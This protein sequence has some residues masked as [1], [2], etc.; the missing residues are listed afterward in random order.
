MAKE[1]IE[2]KRIFLRNLNIKDAK[3]IVKICHDKSI[4]RF[5]HVP[6]PYRLKDAFE[7]IKRSQKKR[8]ESEEFVYGIINKETDE[9]MGTISFIRISKRDNKAEIGYLLGKEY[10][11]KGYMTE[12]CKLLV[13]YGFKK[14]KFYKICINCAKGNKE[15][16]KVIEKVGGKEEALLRKD[17]LLGGKYHDH[18]IH[19]LWRDDWKKRR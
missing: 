19:S 17:I 9:L 18:Y 4:N 16:K 13:D 2:G 15:S 12:A 6:Y 5:T 14:M 8:K 1:D 11:N 7:F 3:Q 10:R